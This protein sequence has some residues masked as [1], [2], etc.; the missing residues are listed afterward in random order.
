MIYSSP[1]STVAI[2]PVSLG[3]YVFEHAS[4]WSDRPAIIPAMYPWSEMARA[5]GMMAY[6]PVLDELFRR[7]AAHIDRIF[8]ECPAP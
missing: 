5:G 3:D 4:R 2:P 8:K 6:S 7:A 1:L